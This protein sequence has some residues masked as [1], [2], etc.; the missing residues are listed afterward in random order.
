MGIGNN[1]Q[2]PEE[3]GHI[4]SSGERSAT[5]PAREFSQRALIL[6]CCRTKTK[7]VDVD[8]LEGGA[9]GA[10]CADPRA[11]AVAT[12][13]A[14]A[15]WGP[16]RGRSQGC[17]GG[18]N[19]WPRCPVGRARMEPLGRGGARAPHETDVTCQGP[20]ATVTE[21]PMPMAQNNRNLL[22]TA[23]ERQV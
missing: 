5:P 20:G 6:W 11:Q 21:C 16:W 3:H 10:L 4:A 23:L 17:H 7:Q 14:V 13:P 12:P 9:I 18:A 19:L 15:T 1:L 22:S 8:R 2:F